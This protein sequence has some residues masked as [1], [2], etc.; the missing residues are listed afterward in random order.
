MFQNNGIARNTKTKCD[1][2]E[3][4]EKDQDKIFTYN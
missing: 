2:L 1:H 3:N 4:R